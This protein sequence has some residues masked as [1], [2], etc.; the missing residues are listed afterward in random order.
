MVTTRDNTIRIK[1]LYDKRLAVKTFASRREKSLSRSGLRPEAKERG[2]ENMNGF[3]LRMRMR[4]GN[5]RPVR[6]VVGEVR[7]GVS[8]TGVVR[9]NVVAFDEAIVDMVAVDVVMV[10]EV[11]VCVVA[12]AMVVF[13]VV[14]QWRVF[15]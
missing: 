10:G 7:V 15:S 4:R 2:W 13:D 11:I 14:H 3:Y 9:V 5:T 6:F 1:M 12:F 8:A